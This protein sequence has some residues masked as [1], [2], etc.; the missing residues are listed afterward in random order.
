MEDQMVLLLEDLVE[1]ATV[2]KV[3]TLEVIRE[4]QELLILAAVAAEVEVVLQLM[5]V[6]VVQV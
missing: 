6:M 5:V 4:V 1:L 2:D 3:V